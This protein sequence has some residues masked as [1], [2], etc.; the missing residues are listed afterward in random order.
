MFPGAKA[1]GYTRNPDTTFTTQDESYSPNAISAGLK[2]LYV[3]AFVT[4][5]LKPQAIREESDAFLKSIYGH[6]EIP[7]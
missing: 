7:E 6:C 4:P 1:P 5:G 2:P 3:E